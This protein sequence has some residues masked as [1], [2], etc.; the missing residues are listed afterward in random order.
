M[1][2]IIVYFKP[3]HFDNL[4]LSLKE[5][6]FDVIVICVYVR[7]CFVVVFTTVSHLKKTIK[8]DGW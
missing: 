3:I 8:N 1:K 2:F 7:L 5:K 4:L 6:N